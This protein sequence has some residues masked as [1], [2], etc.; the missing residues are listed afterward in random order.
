[1]DS[2]N[3]NELKLAY[4]GKHFQSGKRKIVPADIDK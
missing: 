4:E 1:M 2:K 3:S